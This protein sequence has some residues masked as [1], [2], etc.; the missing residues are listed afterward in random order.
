MM[1]RVEAF[2]P[3]GGPHGLGLIQGTKTVDPEEWF[4]KA[5]FYQDPVWPGSLGLE[6]MLQLLKV[7]AVE[8]WPGRPRFREQLWAGNTAGFTAA[9][10]FPRTARSASRPS[11]RMSMK[12]HRQITADGFL[13]VDG[14]IIYQMSRFTLR[15]KLAGL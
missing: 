10:S 14:R 3:A 13:V 11:S 6:A 15:A 1:D 8:R 12:Q 2:D 4:F 5:H 9:R 7:V